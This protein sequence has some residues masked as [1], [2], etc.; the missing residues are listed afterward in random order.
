MVLT[1]IEGLVGESEGEGEE[2]HIVIKKA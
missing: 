1:E 2:R